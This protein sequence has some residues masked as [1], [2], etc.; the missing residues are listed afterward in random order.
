MHSKKHHKST[1]D[2][3]ESDKKKRKRKALKEDVN[4]L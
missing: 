4:R 1:I 2:N 3:R